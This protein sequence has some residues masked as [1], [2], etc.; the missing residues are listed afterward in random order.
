MIMARSRSFGRKQSIQLA[1]HPTGCISTDSSRKR[2]MNSSPGRNQTSPTFESLVANASFI[3][4]K[5]SVS[6]RVDVMNDSFLVMHQT[7][8]HIEYSI[9]PLG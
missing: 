2:H 4:R 5:G 1:M 6:L 9:K 8:K 7:P 3:R